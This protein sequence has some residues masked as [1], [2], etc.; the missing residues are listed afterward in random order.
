MR[1]LQED[2]EIGLQRDAGSESYAGYYREL[3]LSRTTDIIQNIDAIHTLKAQLNLPAFRA[4]RKMVYAVVRV[5][6]IVSE[7]WS[8]IRSAFT[9][10][11]FRKSGPNTGRPGAATLRGMIG[12]GLK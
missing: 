5:L 3:I 12:T 11:P 7:A 1:A 9:R 4:D 10:I 2:F 6:E 8:C